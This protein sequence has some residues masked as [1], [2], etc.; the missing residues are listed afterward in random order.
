MIRGIEI[1]YGDSLEFFIGL[2]Q[3]ENS[4]Y[5]VHCLNFDDIL[6]FTISN[7]D[8]DGLVGN[9]LPLYDAIVKAERHY[10]VPFNIDCFSFVG[11]EV[12]L[13]GKEVSFDSL[14]KN[15]LPVKGTT[16]G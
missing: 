15:D 9:K 3:D 14:P 6:I 7:Q 13:T 1:L 10:L 5:I 11:T 4:K 12:D 8:L 2:A 16:L